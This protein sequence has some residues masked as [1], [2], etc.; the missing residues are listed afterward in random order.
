MTENFELRCR[1]C[2]KY[3]TFPHEYSPIGSVR[4]INFREKSRNWICPECE[5]FEEFDK[6]EKKAKLLYDFAK[7]LLQDIKNNSPF[8]DLDDYIDNISI[9]D[10]LKRYVQED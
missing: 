8:E 2:F 7:D 6:A 3:Y 9:A 10:F 1:R 4:D 5:F